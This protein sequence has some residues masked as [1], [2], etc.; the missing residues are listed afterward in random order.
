MAEGYSGK[1]KNQ[2]T[3]KVEAPRQTTPS[4]TGKV[5]TGKDLRTGRK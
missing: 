2:G 5:K 3:Q 4:K 1:I